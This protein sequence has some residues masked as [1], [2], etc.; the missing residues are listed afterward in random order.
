MREKIFQRRKKMIRKGNL[1]KMTY[2]DAPGNDGRLFV[3]SPIPN[4]IYM[5]DGDDEVVSR[6]SG[7]IASMGSGNDFVIGGRL[8]F[9]S[10]YG[11]TGDDILIARGKNNYLIGEEGADMLIGGS[12]NDVII[13]DTDDKYVFGDEG[14][15]IFLLVNPGVSGG[16]GEIFDFNGNPNQKDHDVLNLS[17]FQGL[18]HEQLHLLHIKET[19]VLYIEG[20]AS[21]GYGDTV[22]VGIN[23]DGT[24]GQAFAY[25]VFD[26]GGKG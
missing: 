1:K 9:N 6:D 16:I 17:S 19:H 25:G 22:L 10:L 4:G 2:I 12:E 18:K 14:A 3:T 23:F 13:F 5:E 24:V 20:D 8:G 15:D 11:G 7:I 26:I 21:Q